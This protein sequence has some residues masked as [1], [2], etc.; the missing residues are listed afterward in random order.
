MTRRFAL[1]IAAPLIALPAANAQQAT[2][3][4]Q[5]IDALTQMAANSMGRTATP[6]DR[7]IKLARCPEQATVAAIDAQTLAVRC[8]SLGWRLRV[9]MTPPV[10]A[11]ATPAGFAAP[12]STPAIRRGD[13]VRVSIE[14][15]SFSVSYSAVATQDGRV[16]ETIALRGNDPKNLMSAVV[17]GP[18]RARLMD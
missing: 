7:R 1:C 14:T 4:W 3:D 13:A 10:G 17:T 6:I 5:T 9:P 8:A 16:G 12:A 2:E 18:G 11:T 15:E